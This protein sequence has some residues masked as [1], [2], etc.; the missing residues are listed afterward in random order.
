VEQVLEAGA[1]GGRHRHPA[2]LVG[3]APGLP[4]R[5]PVHLVEDQQPLLL[6]EPEVLQ[7]R[8]DRLDLLV[9]PRVG[10]VDDVQQEV[11]VAELLERRAERGDEVL[12]QVADEADGVGDD[13]LA[14]GG[15][16]QPPAGGVERREQH[17][18]AR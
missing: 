10:G 5:Q 9:E 15:E 11:G 3:D 7:D 14:L 6:V 18:R 1:R 8:V 16:P 13:H 12:R 17:V 4:R 2:A